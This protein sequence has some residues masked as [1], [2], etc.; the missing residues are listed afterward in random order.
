[1]N[2]DGRLTVDGGRRNE[3]LIFGLPQLAGAATAAQIVEAIVIR[4]AIVS[5]RARSTSSG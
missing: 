5:S 4:S 2:K 3:L 1:M